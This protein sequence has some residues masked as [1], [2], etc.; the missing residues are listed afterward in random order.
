MA[1]EDAVID[2]AAF[3]RKAHMRAA[4]VEREDLAVLV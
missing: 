2:A 3:E 4:I 1:G